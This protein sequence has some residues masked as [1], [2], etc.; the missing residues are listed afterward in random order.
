MWGEISGPE[1]CAQINN[2][3]EVV[4]WR[5]NI[6][7]VP[8]GKQ[9]TAFV[10]ELACLYQTYADA[11]TLECIAL[12]VSTVF[13]C[14][15]LQKPCMQKANNLEQ[16]LLLWKS[17]NITALLHEGRCIQGHIPSPVSTKQ[18]MEKNARVFSRLMFKSKVIAALHYTSGDV[19]GGVL[20][21]DDLI[22]INEANIQPSHQ[23]TRSI[24]MEK[25]PVGRSARPDILLSPESD[26]THDLVLFEQ[27]TGEAIKQA[28]FRTRGAAGPSGV[29][30]YL[31]R[32]LCSSFKRASNDL[33]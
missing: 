1:F 6:F 19:K 11:S 9:G 15:M 28:V 27:I 14:L 3:N 18:D 12:K 31:W 8:S 5:H 2:A 22:P 23:S 25:H 13:Q 32:R 24:L 33:H 17:G 10:T 7:Q 30:A 4:H 29:D 26:S 16:Q 21:L 20:S